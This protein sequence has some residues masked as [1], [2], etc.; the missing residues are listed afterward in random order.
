MR[1]L[2]LIIVSA[3]IVLSL[4]FCGGYLF[5]KNQGN[6]KKPDPNDEPVMDHRNLTI[7]NDTDE[8]INQLRILLE[9]RTEIYSE[10]NPEDK[11]VLVPIDDAYK[12]YSVFIVE[13]IDNYDRLYSKKQDNV[14]EVGRTAITVT[15]EDRVKQEGDGWKDLSDWFNDTFGGKDKEN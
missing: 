5:G 12:K 11:S 3:V 14:P 9:D 4:A 8:V 10:T 2:V 6:N 7:V 1:K 13:L 15:K